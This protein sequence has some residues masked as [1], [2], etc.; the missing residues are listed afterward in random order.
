MREYCTI[1]ALVSP[2][3]AAGPVL[4]TG[5]AELVSDK[6]FDL[7]LEMDYFQREIDFDGAGVTCINVQLEDELPGQLSGRVQLG[8]GCLIEET[9][10]LAGWTFSVSVVETLADD[11]GS[12]PD[13]LDAEQLLPSGDQIAASLLQGIQHEQ[14][15]YAA[16]K[17]FRAIPI[18]DLSTEDLNSLSPTGHDAALRRASALAGCLMHAAEIVIDEL[19]DD[20]TSLRDHDDAQT[21]DIAET[22][23][24]GQLPRRFAAN[25]TALFAQKF[26]VAT[27]DLTGRLTR[28]WESLACVAQELGLRI[29]LNQVE[30]VAETADVALDDHWRSH[31]EDLFFEDLD[32]EFLYDPAYDGI[33]DDPASQPP[34]M[35]P[36]RFGDWFVPFSEDR[37]MPPYALPPASSA[38]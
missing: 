24:L 12:G 31:L 3:A 11:E 21:P 13:G 20:I 33:E 10:E 18:E 25:Y 22:W 5:A 9:P 17:S 8:L 38:T 7:D 35:A 19:I 2:P 26:L 27:V 28:G 6:I 4:L 30:V 32:H 15:V 36:M 1:K 29:L 14:S 16:A 23:I 37:T 34:G